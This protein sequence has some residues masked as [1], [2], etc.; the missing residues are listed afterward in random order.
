MLASPGEFEQT[1]IVRRALLSL[2]ECDQHFWGLPD[3]M[4][5]RGWTI[6]IDRTCRC[7]AFWDQTDHTETSVD[8]GAVQSLG[9]HQ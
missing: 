3:A 8:I 2:G 4:Q 9:G 5:P 7:P 1:I 6:L